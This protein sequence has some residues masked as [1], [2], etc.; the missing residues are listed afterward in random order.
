METGNACACLT[1]V[2]CD[3]VAAGG[4]LSFKV[5]GDVT[6]LCAGDAQREVSAVELSVD[7]AAHDIAAA[8][9]LKFAAERALGFRAANAGFEDDDKE[10]VVHVAAP[11]SRDIDAVRDARWLEGG[12]DDGR[13][14]RGRH[15]G[16]R[17]LVL[18]DAGDVRGLAALSEPVGGD[19]EYVHD[20][21]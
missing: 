20:A 14:K 17:A 11:A 7:F 13:F 19:D 5:P 18:D 6:G 15:D 3:F 12:G 9:V 21:R 10:T 2:A 16:R 4:D 1:P 8:M